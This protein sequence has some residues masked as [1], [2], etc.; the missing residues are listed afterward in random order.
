VGSECFL[1]VGAGK[2]VQFD[3]YMTVFYVQK[4]PDGFTVRK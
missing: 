3:L 4:A 2:D 1:G